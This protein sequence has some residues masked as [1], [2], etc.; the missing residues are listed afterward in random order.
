MSNLEIIKGQLAGVRQQA[1]DKQK[2]P[3]LKFDTESQKMYFQAGFVEPTND[4]QR[5]SRFFELLPHEIKTTELQKKLQSIQTYLNDTLIDRDEEVMLTLAALVSKQHGF[6]FGE[7]GTG[8]SYIYKLLSDCFED[9]KYFQYLMHKQSE[10]EALFGPVSLQELKNDNYCY[11][12]KGFLAESDVAFLDEIFKCNAGILNSLLT[13][14]NERKFDNGGQRVSVPLVSMFCASNELPEDE[15]LAALWDR[16]VFRV[17]VHPVS[18]KESLIRILKMNDGA[19]KKPTAPKLTLKDLHDMQEE[20][21]KMP[22]REEVF[23]ALAEVDMKIKDTF[24]GELKV[25]VRRLAMIQ[26]LLRGMAYL[27]GESEVS[28]KYVANIA[29]CLWEKPTQIETLKKMLQVSNSDPFSPLQN[30]LMDVQRALQQVNVSLS[31]VKKESKSRSSLDELENGIKRTA[32]EL[33]GYYMEALKWAAFDPAIA[34]DPRLTSVLSQLFNASQVC[35]DIRSWARN[36]N[37]EIPECPTIV[38]K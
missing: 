12:T 14:L 26:Q 7:P 20:V 5:L 33:V 10:P 30:K 22:M 36:P 15:S 3:M 19:I 18:K 28:A 35:S 11:K 1:L 9:M 31:S 32:Q 8:K 25:S 2:T 13:V 6:L 17:V 4:A 27:N 23:T 37:N 24:K 16:I 38:I 34:S 21:A 29:N